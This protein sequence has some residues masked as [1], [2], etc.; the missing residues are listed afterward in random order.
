MLKL[1]SRDRFANR[2]D[3]VWIQLDQLRLLNLDN[4]QFVL[5]ITTFYQHWIFISS[6]KMITTP[7]P[8][9]HHLRHQ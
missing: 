4:G 8:Q 2:F 3:L 7:S 5:A 1:D 6:Q 9:D